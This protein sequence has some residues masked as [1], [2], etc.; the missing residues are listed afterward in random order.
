ML[1][2]EDAQ[3]YGRAIETLMHYCQPGVG[4]GSTS[5]ACAGVLLA[6]YAG[7]RWVMHL[8]RLWGLDRELQEAALTVI[9]IRARKG[10]EPHRYIR[11]GD[12]R[13]ADLQRHYAQDDINIEEIARRVRRERDRARRR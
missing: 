5:T 9:D 6:A 8:D 10:V 1:S 7:R 12:H 13:F 11:D 3:R 2:K 4:G